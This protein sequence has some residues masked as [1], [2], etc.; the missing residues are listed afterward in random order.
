ME[1]NWT[2]YKAH[3]QWNPVQLHYTG[4]NEAIENLSGFIKNI[5]AP[6]TEDILYRIRDTSHLLGII[7]TINDEDLPN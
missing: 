1:K 6:L 2:P 3:I 5:G 4:C 7:D